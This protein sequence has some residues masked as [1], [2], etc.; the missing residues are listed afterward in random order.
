MRKPGPKQATPKRAE[1]AEG[2]D[3]PMF[4][5][6]DRTKTA[7]ADAAGEQTPAITSQKSKRNP[8]FAE[9]GSPHSIKQQAADPAP[10]GR[11]AK[12]KAEAIG[13]EARPARP[14]QLRNLREKQNAH[15]AG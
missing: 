5:K 10:P 14:G 6:G 9:G 12:A 2:G 3:T 15:Q 13:G 1:L 4:G 8:K 7:T 11:T